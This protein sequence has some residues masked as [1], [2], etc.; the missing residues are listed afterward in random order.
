MLN[1]M[2]FRELFERFYFISTLAL[3]S[4]AGTVASTLTSPLDVVKTRMQVNVC[5]CRRPNMT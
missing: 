2:K 4:V 3:C 1:G 5:H